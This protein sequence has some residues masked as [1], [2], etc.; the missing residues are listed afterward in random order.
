[1]DAPFLKLLGLASS[2]SLLSNLRTLSVSVVEEHAPGKAPIPLVPGQSAA[3]TQGEDES[4]P[5]T[6]RDI[7]KFARKMS[8]LSV[9]GKTPRTSL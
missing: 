9:L 3:V 2:F 5:S 7:K 4:M 6:V 1:M 8:K